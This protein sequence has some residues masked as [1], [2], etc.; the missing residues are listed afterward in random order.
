FAQSNDASGVKSNPTF[1]LRSSSTKPVGPGL[2]TLA[3]MIAIVTAVNAIPTPT[4]AR[5]LSPPT[6]LLNIVIPTPDALGHQAHENSV[7]RRLR[8]KR[9]WGNGLL[10]A[11]ERHRRRALHETGDR[12]DKHAPSRQS[13]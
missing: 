12:P 11:F 7:S 10:R 1:A 8:N 13:A 6:L 2:L 9:I 5:K 4:R 3:Q